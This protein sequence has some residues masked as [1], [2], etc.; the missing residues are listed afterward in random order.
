MIEVGDN[1]M[2]TSSPEVPPFS[3]YEVHFFDKLAELRS[4]AHRSP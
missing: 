1:Q 2:D 3:E 4:I